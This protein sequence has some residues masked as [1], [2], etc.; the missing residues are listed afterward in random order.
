MNDIL[1][2]PM[3]S[4]YPNPNQPRHNFDERALQELS[5]SI[6]EYGVMSPIL[7]TPRPTAL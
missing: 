6:K 7:V 4:I 1:L 2:L 3:T 5:A